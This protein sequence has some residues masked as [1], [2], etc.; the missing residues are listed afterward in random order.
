[1]T[2]L[3]LVLAL[4]GGPALA[5][6][7]GALSLQEIEIVEGATT[8]VVLVLDG[9][10]QGAA[11]SSF[12]LSDPNQ[13]VVD[14][15]DAE[16]DPAVTSLV[17]K[18]ALIDRIEAETFDDGQGRIA[19]LR[20]YVAAD[21]THRVVADGDRIR[22]TLVPG[23]AGQDALAAALGAG[24]DA[25]DNSDTTTAAAS[26]ADAPRLLSGPEQLPDAPALSSLDFQNL[27]VTSRIVIGTSKGSIE[28][29]DSQPRSDLIVLDFPNAFI[30]QSLT[31]PLDT[32][33]FISPVKMVRA[34]RTS[35]GGRVAISLRS[36]TTYTVQRAG[37]GLI[38]VDVAVPASMREDRE[39]AQQ[40][41]SDV[42]PDGGSEEGLK[43]AYQEEIF[44]GSSGRTVNPQEA[45][46]TGSGSNDPSAVLGMSAGFMMDNN[47]ASSVPFTGRRISLDFVN[48]DIHAIFR[49][50]SHVARLNIVA[51]D[52]VKG[53]VTVR[54]EDV[55]WDQALAAILQA[56][57]LGSQRFGNIIRVA[58]IESIKAEQQAQL[59]AKRAKEE[60]E[61][62]GL[63][64]IPLNY[65]Q[66][67]DIQTQ[68]SPL[69]SQ[70]GSVQVDTRANQLIIQ[71]R[72]DRLV[73][74]RE[75][76]RHLDKQ[77][78]QVLIEARVVEATTAYSK[79][80]GIQWGGELDLSTATGASTG[81]FF[82]NS[83]GVSG[84][85]SQSNSGGTIFY[86]PGQ[87]NLIVDTG[88]DSSNGSLAMSLGSITGLINLDVRLSAMESEGWG[89]VISSPRITTLDNQEATISQGQKVPFLSTSSGGTQVQFIQAALD[90]A[91]TPHITSDN[92]IFLSVKISN[93]RPDFSQ[94]VQGQPAIQIKEAETTLLVA[95]GD[96]TVLGGVFSTEESWSQDRVPGFSKIPLLGYLFKNS[97][98]NSSRN[99][100]LVFI[101]PRIVT[102]S[103]AEPE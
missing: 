3:G 55:P 12:T 91:V 4:S 77:T 99:E 51:G 66:A 28:V 27:D 64:V 18:T 103:M 14:I 86:S 47:S 75:L 69:M 73:Q 97:S 87:D 90:L 33:D 89:K 23:Q 31:R 20:I 101:T 7:G 8:Q 58:P 19:R 59:E 76:V 2:G 94:L 93:N 29:K 100:M 71:D 35:T 62:L 65:G 95:D 61:E 49:L 74:I 67:S 70:R 78:P 11:V 83:I 81:L 32:E 72:E 52:D 84:G 98:E 37:S 68:I 45:W 34:Y 53:T 10:A 48:A 25:S 79:S 15:A 13:I 17:D 82:P 40:G 6:S 9:T 44:I 54:M 85:N 60:L 1:M 46:G 36:N 39:V 38:Y 92:K 43:N 24:G 88:A 57:S 50:I 22:L 102:R 63:L 16:V 42:S 21:V 30:P 5:Q 56:K 80:L 26:A 41:W 96:T